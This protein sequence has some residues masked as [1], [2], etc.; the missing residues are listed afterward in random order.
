MS[1]VVADR[2]SPRASCV[3]VDIGDPLSSNRKLVGINV[4]SVLNNGL[5]STELESYPLDWND[6]KVLLPFQ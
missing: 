5:I 1:G 4:L 6:C 3:M 2:A